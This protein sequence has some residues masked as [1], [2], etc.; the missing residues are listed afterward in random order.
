MIS[1]NC[2]RTFE[3]VLQESMIRAVSNILPVSCANSHWVC[4]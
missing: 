2:S 4:A 3:K 1:A